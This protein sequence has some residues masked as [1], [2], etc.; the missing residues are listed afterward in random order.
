MYGCLLSP[1]DQ[2]IMEIVN[3]IV[4]N[5]YSLFIKDYNI[6]KT[7]FILIASYFIF[8]QVYMCF[9]LKPTLTY[10][11]SRNMK[12]VDLPEII[13]CP[14]PSYDIEAA[15]LRGYNGIEF[16]YYG[17]KSFDI[18]GK[19]EPIGWAGS[20]K[21]ESVR[22]VAEEL[23]VLKSAD[24]CPKRYHSYLWFE[25]GSDTFGNFKLT[26]ALYPYHICCK[27]IPPI[28]TKPIRV[29]GI[30]IQFHTSFKV[31]LADQLT[32]S[33]FDQ[34]K[35]KMIGDDIK[36]NYK[37]VNNYRVKILEEEKLENDPSSLCIDYKVEQ[38]YAKCL[39]DEI[40]RQNSKFMNCTPP[41]MTEIEDLWCINRNPSFSRDYMTIFLTN[42][43]FSAADPGKC[44]VPCKRKVF[45]VKRVGLN[46]NSEGN[47]SGIIV[48]FDKVVEVT[49]SEFQIGIKSLVSSIGGF[50]GIS[51][52]FLWLVLLIISSIG[53]FL[54]KAK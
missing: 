13:L 29:Q 52:N 53:L 20:I 49:K 45:E 9:V 42:I 10:S 28:K 25:D 22:R 15:K 26:K 17:V 35:V 32:A 41:W 18:G 48:Y 16:Y 37:G 12:F 7:F 2:I 47:R 51:K 1:N 44:L 27:L 14:E 38:E 3:N 24:D 33:M 50:I 36:A 34:N 5:S 43:L 23:S 31:F 11:T 6:I 8:E 46:E 40:M 4:K 30:N 19:Y 54:A 21:S 39:E